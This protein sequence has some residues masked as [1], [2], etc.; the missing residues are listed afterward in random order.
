MADIEENVKVEITEE[1]KIKERIINLTL[2]EQGFQSY[3][4]EKING[5]FKTLI[6][7]KDDISPIRLIIK[8][9]EHEVYLFNKSVEKITEVFLLK[10]Q[11]QDYNGI[12]WQFDV[13]EI[14]L[15]D[16][17][18]MELVGK[19]GQNVKITIRYE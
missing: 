4:T 18:Y 14:P 5:Y 13:T 16:S 2:N 19:A 6:I 10:A 9:A 12:N 7:E 3:T 17:L 15:N 1:E 11:P 8:L